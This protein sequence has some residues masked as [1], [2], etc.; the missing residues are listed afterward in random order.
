MLHI[1]ELAPRHVAKVEDVVHQGD[2]LKLKI[3]KVEPNGKISLSLKDV[4]DSENSRNG[5]DGEK[6]I[7]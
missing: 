7:K 1:S 5:K 6:N 3:K 2:V 4:T